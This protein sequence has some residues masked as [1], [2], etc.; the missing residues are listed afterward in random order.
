MKRGKCVSQIPVK[1]KQQQRLFGYTECESNPRVTRR[2]STN[3]MELYQKETMT[4]AF[5]DA[6]GLSVRNVLRQIY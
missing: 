3:I 5:S 4:S 1:K 6:I 2:Q